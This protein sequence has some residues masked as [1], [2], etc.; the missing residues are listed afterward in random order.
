[1][2]WFDIN[3]VDKIIY[4]ETQKAAY[5]EQCEQKIMHQEQ[6]NEN[7]FEGSNDYSDVTMSI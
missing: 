6:P 7:Y 4:E 3:K 1:M 5:E 2:E